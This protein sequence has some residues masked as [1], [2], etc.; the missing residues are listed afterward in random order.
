MKKR[1]PVW[2]CRRGDALLWAIVKSARFLS[3][4][5]LRVFLWGLTIRLK[6]GAI[7]MIS[8]SAIHEKAFGQCTSHKRVKKSF[9]FSV[10]LRLPQ[11]SMLLFPLGLGWLQV[12]N[13]GVKSGLWFIWF[14]ESFSLLLG[15]TSLPSWSWPRRDHVICTKI[16]VLKTA[17]FGDVTPNAAA[18]ARCSSGENRRLLCSGSFS[19]T[20][21]CFSLSYL[22]ASALT[23]R[24][25]PEWFENSLAKDH[26]VGLYRGSTVQQYLWICFTSYWKSA[27][28]RAGF[29]G[30]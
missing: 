18:M 8:C 4:G 7:F 1:H 26:S 13:K 24:D 28:S 2:H 12:S 16:R 25:G 11:L 6:L 27:D 5:I 23:C 30:I 14:F 15:Y 29:Y 9:I 20:R 21:Q 19:T 10:K 17:I 3:D 22:S